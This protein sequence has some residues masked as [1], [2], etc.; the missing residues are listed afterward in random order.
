MRSLAASTQTLPFELGEPRSFHGLTLTPLFPAEPPQLDYIGLDEAVARG[1]KIDEIDSDGAVQ[2]LVVD[3]PLADRVL[4]YEGEEL[5]GAKQNRIIRGTVL[6]E[7]TA[8]MKLAVHC[9]E[10]GRW[11]LDRKSVV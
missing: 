2:T 11:S 5:V 4:F 7:A 1:L 8:T 3:N 9:V 10:R 6:V